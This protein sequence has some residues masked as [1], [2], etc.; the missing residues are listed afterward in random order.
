MTLIDDFAE[1]MVHAVTIQ[2]CTG[3]DGYADTFAEGV[4]YAC[5]VEREVKNITKSDGTVI[6]STMQIHLDGAVVVSGRDKITFAGA[7]PRILAVETDYD[8]EKPDE[9]YS[10]VVYT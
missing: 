8:I 9:I 10:V 3:N 7:T 4:S 2:S 6:V 5:M 1:D